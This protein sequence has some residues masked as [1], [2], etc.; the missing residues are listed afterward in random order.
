MI[1]GEAHPQIGDVQAFTTSG[2]GMNC[3]EIAD[4]ALRKIIHIADTAP[5]ELRD[6]AH[7]F[8]E[9]I[10]PVLIRYLHQAIKSDRTTLHNQLRAAGFP[11]VAD[12]VLRI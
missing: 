9:R 8:K 5:P 7:Q 11:D 4:L 3:E 10:R 6:Q 1:S 12:I 2:R